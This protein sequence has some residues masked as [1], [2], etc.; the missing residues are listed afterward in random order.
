MNKK[1]LTTV[2]TF[3]F[4]FFGFL[5]IVFLGLAVLS[6]NI[7]N[8]NLGQDVMIGQVNLQNATNQTFGKI[9]NGFID[10]A[11]NMGVILLLGMALLMIG[12]GYVVGKKWPK[13][14]IVVDIFILVFAVLGAVYISQTFNTLINSTSYFNVFGDNLPN[15]SAFILNLPYIS[16]ILGILIMI[17]TY[18]GIN[19]E[20]DQTQTN[21]L[22]YG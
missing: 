6:F 5:G 18:S 1:G 14:W 12:Q 16:A 7:I 21:V 8:I 15:S 22:G 9:S 19:R 2:Q 13:A 20:G 17:F 10:N 3:L 4:I 11:D